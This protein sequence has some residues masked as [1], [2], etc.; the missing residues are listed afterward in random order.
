M[1]RETRM[2]TNSTSMNTNWASLSESDLYARLNQIQKMLKDETVLSARDEM[3]S[4]LIAI[5]S[6]FHE[7]LSQ[8]VAQLQ[9]DVE[10]W[11]RRAHM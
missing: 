3:Q 4:S 9:V 2:R 1:N 10:R 11:K 5:L 7:R 8:Q 6:Q